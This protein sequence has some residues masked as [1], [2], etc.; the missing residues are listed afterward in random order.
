MYSITLISFIFSMFWSRHQKWNGHSDRN[1]NLYQR[2]SCNNLLF[3][4]NIFL[5]RFFSLFFRFF[6]FL[7]VFCRVPYFISRLLW[8]LTTSIPQIICNL[9]SDI[10]LCLTYLILIFI[11]WG[12]HNYKSEIWHFLFIL[13]LLIIVLS[14][15]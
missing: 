3:L 5:F 11:L 6:R 9:N 8:T 1:R 12:I 13:R 15:I 4:R 14:L 2:L 7:S 10:I